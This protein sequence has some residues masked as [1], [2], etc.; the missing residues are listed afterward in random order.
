MNL[1]EKI[2]P[3]IVLLA[4]ASGG[5]T[6]LRGQSTPVRHYLTDANMA[7]GLLGQTA[8]LTNPRLASVM[9]PVRIILPGSTTLEAGNSAGDYSQSFAASATMGMMVGPVYR[10]RVSNIQDYPGKELYP[11]IE[12]L[13]RLYP[14]A[15]Q[16]T[17]FPI[18]IH[19]SQDDLEQALRGSMVTKVIYLEDPNIAFPQTHAEGRQP[20]F[21]VNQNEDPLRAAEVLGHPMAIV[22]MGSRIPTHLPG[23]QGFHFNAP[24]PVI[25]PDLAEEM[26]RSIQDSDRLE[27]RK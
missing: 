15:G 3:A 20:S 25:L 8:L 17:R 13:N 11:S 27:T 24:M 2:W 9:Q 19:L 16:E 6:E 23:D 10:F 22:R 1:T 21:D 18:E 26:D 4:L 14:P 12:I 7:P 5:A